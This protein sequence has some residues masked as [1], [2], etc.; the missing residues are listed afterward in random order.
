MAATSDGSNVF[1][2]SESGF[3][4]LPVSQ[5]FEHPILQPETTQVFLA[6]DECNKGIARATVN[7]SNL[8]QG[9]LTFSVPTVTTALVTQLS[10][11]VAPASIEF[12]MEPGRSGVVRQPGTN[13]FTNAVGG[14]GTPLNITLAS[15]EAINFPNTIRVYMNYRQPDQRGI[16]FPRPVS[17]NNNQGLQELILDEARGRLYITNSGFNR[18]EIFDTNQQRFL[19]PLE[20]GQLP[21]SMAMSLDGSTLYIGNTGG[22]SI[23]VVDLDSLTVTGGIEFPPIPRAGNQNPVQPVALAMGL[24]GLQFIMSNGTFWQVVGN[25]ATPRQA[26][27]ITPATIGA[28]QYMA[29]TPGGRR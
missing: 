9:K 28:P 23:A 20:I 11:G 21:R 14:G 29:A 25:Q 8:G 22:E 2:L 24:S 16:I 13:L 27:S 15:Q 10:S 3:L 19:E 5:I 17:L 12:T 4:E 1:A 6:V 26:S 7:V 18:L